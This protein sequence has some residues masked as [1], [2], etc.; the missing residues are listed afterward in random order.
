MNVARQKEAH[1]KTMVDFLEQLKRLTHYDAVQDDIPAR[2]LIQAI[3][4]YGKKR[5]KEEE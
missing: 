3:Y 1:I 5:G 2:Q 4:E